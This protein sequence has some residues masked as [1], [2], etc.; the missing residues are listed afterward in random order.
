MVKKYKSP[1]KEETLRKLVHH[2]R[3]Q[4]DLIETFKNLKKLIVEKAL[5]G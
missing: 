5:K 3:T 2:C 4:E 1:F